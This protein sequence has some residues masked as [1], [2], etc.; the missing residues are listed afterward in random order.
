MLPCHVHWAQKMLLVFI[1]VSAMLGIAAKFVEIERPVLDS[2]SAELIK[3]FARDA[4][5]RSGVIACQIVFL[6]LGIA[7]YSLV[8]IFTY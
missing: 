6:L 4:R 1:V 8:V 3:K 5:F 7:A 2:P